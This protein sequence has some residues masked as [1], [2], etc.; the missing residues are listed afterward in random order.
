MATDFSRV[1]I[2]PLLD[3]AAVLLKQGAVLLDADANE[4]TAILDRRLRALAGDV[5]GR[6]TVG[7]NTPDAF[8]IALAAGGGLTI[9]PGR[10]YVDG[11]PAENHGAA[12][13]AAAA[14]DALL[15]EA[16]YT[17]AIP[18]DAQ[19]YLPEP[20]PLPRAGRHL[21]YLDVWEREVTH[22]EQ[23]ALVEPA[24]GVDTSSRLQTVWQVRVLDGEVPTDVHCGAP[25]ADLAGWADLTAPSGGRLTTGTYEEAAVD[26]P[27]ELPP[28]GGYRGLENQLYRVEIHDAGQGGGGATFKWSRSNAS[29]GSRVAR[30]VSATQLEL[31]SLGPDEVRSMKTGDWV[32]VIDDVREFAR[33][34]GE[35]RQITG[36]APGSASITLATALPADLLPATFPD[37]DFGRLRNTRVRLWHQ[38]GKVL[39]AAG[40]GTTAVFQD[41]AAPGSTGLIAVPGPGTTLLLENGITVRFTSTGTKGFRS[42]DYWVFA[43]RTG[44]ASVETLAAAPPRGIH[45]HYARLALWDAGTATEPTD[46]RNKWPPAG[47]ADCGCTQCVTPESHA[48]GQLTIADA[49]RRVQESGGTVCLHTGRYTLREPVRVTGAR[50]VRIHGQGPA[51]VLVAPIGAFSIESALGLAIDGLAM[52]TTGKTPA[53]AIRSGAGIALH[54]LVV[55]VANPGAPASGIALSGAIAGLVIRDNLIVGPFGIKAL[56]P[57]APDPLAILVTTTLRIENNVL[58]CQRHGM[59]FS[60]SVGH[61]LSSI[62]SGNELFGARD[63]GISMLGFALPGASMRIANNNLNV[64]GPGIRCAVDGA[65]IEGNKLT[66]VV[67]EDKAPTGAGIALL[68]GLDLSGSDQCQLLGNQVSGFPDA[69]IL[70]DAPVRDLLCKLNIVENCGNGIVMR[71]AAGAGSVSIENNHLRNIG[72]T[73]PQ[74][75][76]GAFVHGISLQRVEN[77]TVAGNTLRGIGADAPRGIAIVAGIALFAVRRSQVRDNTI[78]GVGPAT[79]LTG[80]TLAGILLHGPYS[81]NEISGNHVE[82]DATAAAADRALWSAV[83]ADEPNDQRPI[84]HTGEF[85]TVLTATRMLVLDGTHAFADEATLD[86]ADPVAPVRRQSST[87][88]RGNV[89]HGRGA[90][91]LVSIESGADIRFGDNR[92]ELVGNAGTAV[93]LRSGAAVVSA[94][95]IRGGEVSLSLSTAVERAAVLGNATSGPITVNQRPLAGTAWD[96]LNVRI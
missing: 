56:D 28:T 36:V 73:R 75:P 96:A 1:R 35:V 48:S 77:V 34:A 52:I 43:A 53:I 87:S 37:A 83:L 38:R 79:G 2:D 74:P 13:P 47:G 59:D 91:P 33:A 50:S 19:P 3:H 25:D 51:T 84:V 41:L 65:W 94:N 93:S 32:E 49:V 82:R 45:H 78:A 71:N 89:L 60:G 46:C 81:G 86:F 6:A 95:F 66:A 5:L 62:V 70:I 92:C 80:A 58:W 12:D 9:G 54:D 72:S 10:L 76:L 85:T 88:L 27:C 8:R 22:L 68:T 42:G 30:I 24:V 7:A 63:A 11:L 40:N 69:G 17:S 44:D 29:D 15:G 61:M 57:T 31:D 67:S 16:R 26:D 90:A 55:L 4:L 14:F 18:Y 64:N 20:P 23:P 39:S 21:V